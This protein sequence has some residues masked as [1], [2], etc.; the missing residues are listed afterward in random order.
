[1][2][3]NH[4]FRT[5]KSHRI[6][7]FRMLMCTLN[8][9]NLFF[10][11][12]DLAFNPLFSSRENNM[13]KYIRN[14]QLSTDGKLV[15]ILVTVGKHWSKARVSNWSLLAYKPWGGHAI[16]WCWLFVATN[17]G[18]DL[19]KMRNSVTNEMHLKSSKHNSYCSGLNVF[20]TRFICVI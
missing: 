17:F 4:A 3:T 8:S 15:K 18:E 7:P 19:I 10:F 2:F 9:T 20:T 14:T 1:M 12:D 13:L 5:I 11:I 16:P 6:C